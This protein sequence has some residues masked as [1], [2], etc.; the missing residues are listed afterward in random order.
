LA[1]KLAFV[2]TH[3]VTANLLLRGQLRYL[4]ERGYE[5]TVIA[6][7]GPDLD[8]VREREGVQTIGIE[9]SRDVRLQEGPAALLSLTR[10]LRALRP[11]VVNAST[12]KAGLLGML[13]AR[14]LGIPRRVYLL[15]GLRGEATTGLAGLALG[16]AEHVAARCA[17]H[18]VCV[19]NSLRAAYVAGGFARAEKTTV[20]PS[21]G[22]DPARFLERAR[23][24]EQ[25]AA[26]RAELGIPPGA[27][28]AGFVG[29]L[30]A[31]KGIGDL[32]VAMDSAWRQ[33]P[34]LRLLLVGGDLGGD[35]LPPS[36]SDRLDQP[37]ILRVGKV[38]DPAPYYAAM[39]FLVFPSLREGLP[40]VPLEAGACELPAIGYRST[41]VV[42]A[43]GDGITG[44]IV[45]RGDS[46]ALGEAIVAFAKDPQ[47]GRARGR[48]ARVRVLER[49]TNERV[50]AA[51]ARFYDGLTSGPATRVPE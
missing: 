47:L 6:S 22:V 46:A 43:I 21:N 3:G 27:P 9:M 14:A 41:G 11:D 17:T 18:V 16:A 31:D 33:V 2:V 50:W 20:I 45:E 29:R 49:F 8:H 19:S 1:A 12:A 42:D 51:W 32:L 7:P 35:R 25:A 39:D 24:R 37:R 13:A 15:R 44:V 5:I 26:M 4:R 10:A 34:D 48:A 30:V 40:N 23:T 28:V 38:A 36:L